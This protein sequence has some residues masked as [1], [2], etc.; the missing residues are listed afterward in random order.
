MSNVIDSLKSFYESFDPSD[1]Q[2]IDKIYDRD[3]VFRDP[4]HEI[5]GLVSMH[6]YFSNMLKAIDY[7]KFSFGDELIGDNKAYLSWKMY[8]RHKQLNQGN[9]IVLRGVSHLE[10]GEKVVYHE[11]FYDMGAM[12]YEHTPVFGRAV[13]WLKG[14]ILS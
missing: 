13:A 11:D 9:E 14:R 12:V 8:F 10:F 5:E 6:D 3:V 2:L 7:C 1:V 4:L